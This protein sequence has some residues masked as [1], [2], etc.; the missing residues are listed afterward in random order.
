[1]A[2]IGH[3]SLVLAFILSV[4]STVVLFIAGARRQ[5]SLVTLGR[6]LQVA[7]FIA[8]AVA[9][10]ALWAA[11]LTD[12]FSIK[13]VEASSRIDQPLI[14]K[15]SAFWSAQ[16]GSF[17][18]WLL[19]LA[20][21]T[22]AVAY[23]S[24]REAGELLPYALAVLSSVAVFFSIMTAFVANPFATQDPAPL[25]GRGLTPLLQDFGMMAHPVF[26]FLGYVGLSVPFAFGISTLLNRSRGAEW[27]RITRRWTLLAWLFL[28]LGIVI[29]GWWAYRQLGWGGYWAW[30][31]VE[32]AS[33]MPWLVATA[34]F[35]SAMVEE[36]RNLLKNWNMLLV[37]FAFI[38]TIFGTFIV[39]SG[40]INSV[41]AF[42]QS[43]IGPWFLGYIGLLMAA[44]LYLVF[45]RYD[46]LM[47]DGSI[48]SAWSKEASFLLNNL[49][50]VAVTLTVLLGTM[51]PLLS[52]MLGQ[53]VTVGAPYFNRVTGPLFAL[54]VV[55]M[56]VCPLIAWRRASLGQFPKLFLW[57]LV[58]ALAMVVVLLLLGL[59]RTGPLVGFGAAAFALFTILREFVVG[60]RAR[61][62]MT[63][64]NP[65]AALAGLM[66]RNPRRYGGYLVHAGILLIVIGIVGSHFFQ[67]SVK[68]GAV[69]PGESFQVGGYTLTYRG[70]DMLLLPGDVK[71]YFATVEVKKGDRLVDTL[72]PNIRVY[73][74]WEQMPQTGAALHSTWAG[75]VY[76]VLGGWDNDMS[77]SFQ[78]WWNPAVGWIWIGLYVLIFGTLFA[79][80]PRQRQQA[81]KRE[82]RVFVALSELEYDYRMGKVT[83]ADYLVL[84]AELTQ[85][86]AALLD[87]EQNAK[88]GAKPKGGGRQDK[89][90]VRQERK[91]AGP[92][93]GPGVAGGL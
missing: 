13:Y 80:W 83:E 45:D 1:M 15:I 33:F 40:I 52:K 64:Q 16:E 12:D 79:V 18:L 48:E 74:G 77:A 90:A 92:G 34:F 38:L 53:E 47:G 76:V 61:S 31:P 86:A 23:R 93:R 56:G 75:D 35:H 27:L 26:L 46:V 22:V 68:A 28:T 5:A 71:K 30:D 25:D 24:R 55:L 8:V 17:L 39:R 32:N 42:A 60:A 19:M 69:R 44:C 72:E 67:Q 4:V 6:R 11:F 78:A 37:I 50:L 36:R 43:D 49:I 58:A 29:G 63:G 9:S 87:E 88:G 89:G 57:P 21:Y 59:R 41:H 62:R 84:H 14:F 51:Y 73:P 70:V 3:Y 65:G 91:K 7:Q 10:I 20:A 81:A 85:A 66:N 82:R 54:M 2:Q